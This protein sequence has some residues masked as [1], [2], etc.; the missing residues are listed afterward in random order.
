LRGDYADVLILDEWQLMDEDAWQVVGA[1]MLLDKDGDAVFI[2]TP[3]S[4]HSRSASKARD[5]Q[6]APKLF[7]R[8]AA[9]QSGRWAAFHFTSHDNPHISQA[10]LADITSDMTSLA[11]R[12]EIEAQ[13]IDEAPGA[14]WKRETLE[15]GRV[16]KAPDLERIV[17]AIDPTATA[18]GDEAGIIVAGVAG[19]QFYVIEDAS[20]HGSPLQWASAAI[21]AYH[22]FKADRI[23]AE[24]NNGGEMVEQ[25]LR[26]VD[27]TIPYTAV[28]ASRGKATRAE[29]VAAFYEQGQGHHVGA[30]PLL[31][32]EMC[33]WEPGADSPNRMDA[34]VWAGTELLVNRKRSMRPL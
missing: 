3:P 15:A 13:D 6:H 14:M 2:Y 33:Q 28:H 5:P 30:F 23:I 9:D 19:E 24:V 25:T 18:A 1:P 17:V 7:K 10:A 4:L 27:R 16:L 12:Q 21:T 8:A 34:L 29:P 26:T 11:Y 20:L 22:K 31:E 32:D